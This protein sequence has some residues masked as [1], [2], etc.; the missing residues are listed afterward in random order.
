VRVT[1]PVGTSS[2]STGSLLPVKAGL[3]VSAMMGS[4]STNSL[5]EFVEV[6]NPTDT[7]LNVAAIGPMSTPLVI[8]VRDANGADAHLTTSPVHNVIHRHGWWLLVSKE[9]N[10]S[11]NPTALWYAKR[12][13]TYTAANYFTAAGNGAIVFNGSV[14]LSL[15][16]TPQKMLIDKAGWGTQ[17]AGGCEGLCASGF[18]LDY[19]PRRKPLST[20]G[21]GEDTDVNKNDFNPATMVT[22]SNLP[23]GQVDTPQPP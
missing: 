1:N 22:G 5:Y 11:A 17:P 12:D 2:P 20:T 3:L 4:T 19:F 23:K 8:H 21:S 18:N 14:Y 9:A 10:V 13:A 6:Y 16:A 7:D 15:T